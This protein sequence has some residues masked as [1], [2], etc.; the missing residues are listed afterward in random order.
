MNVLLI[1]ANGY[2]G[3]H[4]IETLAPHHHLRITDVKPPPSEIHEKHSRHE[5]RDL[6]VTDADQVL[7]HADGMDAIVNFAVVRRDPVLA[8]NVNTIGC[9]HVMQAAAKHGIRRVINT[10]PH[11]TFAGPSYEQ[12]DFA[13]E[14]DVPPHPGTGLYPITKS[15]GQEICR[16]F[17]EK[18]NVYV[19]E[20]LFY[21]LR[22]TKELKPGLGGIPFIV[23]WSDAAEAFR[24][25]LEIELD[26]LPT[27]C[28]AFFIH[29]DLP[30]DKFS[31]EK[32]RRILGFRPQGDVALLWR[33]PQ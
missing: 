8:F 2:M 14:P 16:V 28:E 5:F 10:G 12:F 19:I 15:L 3:P 22:E 18:H 33:R 30:Q 31:N 9:Y 32:A 13:I 20:L 11:F 6:D 27:R 17:A 26:K 25:A 29:D 24:L 21:I 1:G 23:S 4:V 7:N